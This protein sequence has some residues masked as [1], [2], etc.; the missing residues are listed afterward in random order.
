MP[1]N[2]VSVIIPT[3]QGS[4]KLAA[5]LDGI[6]AQSYN[7]MEV[8]V[9][10]DNGLGTDEQIK[11]VEVVRK[12][13]HV[14]YYAHEINKNGSA[15]RNT[16]IRNSTGD[17]L[18]FLDD[19]DTWLKNK[20]EN[21]V[22][23]LQGLTN[24]WGAVYCPYIE[25]ESEREAY[26]R[27]GGMQGEILFEYLIE[28]VKIASSTIMIRR[29]VLEKV[30]GFDES[31]R[32]HQDWEFI[33]RIAAQYK[34]AFT[35]Q[36][37]TFKHNEARR[38]SPKRLDILIRNR[39]YYVEKM[40]S[41]IG[42]LPSEKQKRVYS[43]HYTFLAKECLRRGKFVQCFK[44]LCKSGYPAINGVGLIKDMLLYITRIKQPCEQLV[45]IW[46]NDLR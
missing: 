16:G 38:N 44:W 22:G 34:I 37:L 19:D 10:D 32:R 42:Q 25:I 40:Q 18:A 6:F 13:P 4:Q 11:T 33:D 43:Y 5:T 31:F 27:A 20:I 35:N 39:L 45:E 28:D 9:V 46:K 12:Y 36:T 15:A 14:H 24:E 23:V 1:N 21:Q 17:F 3:Y 26:F 30:H 2:L 7:N 41:I 29:E 8:I